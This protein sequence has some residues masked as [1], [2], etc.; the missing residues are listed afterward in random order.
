[1]G[2][3]LSPVL[4]LY[5]YR[6]WK[7]IQL[8]SL[9]SRF[10]LVSEAKFKSCRLTHCFTTNFILDTLQQRTLSKLWYL[11][12][13]V[14]EKQLCVRLQNWIWGKRLRNRWSIKMCYIKMF[15]PCIYN[16]IGAPLYSFNARPMLWAQSFSRKAVRKRGKLSWKYARPKM[17]IPW[18]KSRS[19]GFNC[20]GSVD[21]NVTRQP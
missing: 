9:L 12:T 8:I 20:T 3:G 10:S 19:S 18:M 13:A 2:I 14:R 6:V 4:A 15:L 16:S 5:T 1:M 21:T 11:R 7:H 17:P